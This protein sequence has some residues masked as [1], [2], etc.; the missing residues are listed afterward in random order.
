VHKIWRIFRPE[1]TNGFAFVGNRRPEPYRDS[2]RRGG[3]ATLSC[4][5]IPLG[6]QTED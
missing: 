5:R 4:D 3:V 1:K 2:D 6:A